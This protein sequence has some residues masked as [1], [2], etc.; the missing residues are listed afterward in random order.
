MVGVVG[1]SLQDALCDSARNIFLCAVLIF[2]PLLLCKS[3]VHFQSTAQNY[4]NHPEVAF[5]LLVGV[6]GIE[7]TTK[8]L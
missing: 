4:K 1:I 6:V 2:E 7:P 8:W 5:I 3:L